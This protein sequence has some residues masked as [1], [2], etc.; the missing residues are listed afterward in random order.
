[1]QPD[2]SV[3]FPGENRIDC[4]QDPIQWVRATLIGAGTAAA[5]RRVASRRQTYQCRGRIDLRMSKVLHR[6]LTK[7]Q[8]TDLLVIQAGGL[9]TAATLRKAGL[10]DSPACPWCSDQQESLE[11]LWWECPAMSEI[12]RVALGTIN[13]DHASLPRTL[14]IHGLAPEMGNDVDLAFWSTTPGSSHTH[15]HGARED[16]RHI[17]QYAAAEAGIAPE[18]TGKLSMRQLLLRIAGHFTHFVPGPLQPI[19]GAA[20][21]LPNCY[22]DGGISFHYTG[23]AA[24]PGWGGTYMGDTLREQEDLISQSAW[25]DRIN[26]ELQFW[27]QLDGHALSSTRVEGWAI[28]GA[29]L[30]PKPMHLGIDNAAALRHLNDILQGTTGTWR[31]PWGMQHDGDM[32][33]ILENIVTARGKHATKGTKVKGHA[34]DE[35]VRRGLA[36]L[37]DKQ[38]NGTADRMVH[39]GYDSGWQDPTDDDLHH[40]RH[41]KTARRSHRPRL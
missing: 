9:W 30:I 24:L 38:G 33:A 13:F 25:T 37:R 32:W 19:S 6:A 8:Q 7:E 17:P 39:K 1:M 41:A 14:A 27:G 2:G 18:K 28:I 10:I 20:P 12:R 4:M 11:H 40:C 35:E 5:M 16:A 15:T 21:E 22:T 3:S 23:P 31:R 29:H 34:T 36:T 26:G